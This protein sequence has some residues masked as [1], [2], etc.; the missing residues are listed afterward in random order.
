[1]NILD[2]FPLKDKKPRKNQIIALEWLADQDAKYLLLE[3]PVGVGKSAIGVCFAEYLK[4]LHADSPS[5]ASFILT[6]QRILQEQ[7]ANS[8]DR[9]IMSSLYGKS[10]YPCQ[11]RNTT[12]DI[13]SLFKE[14]KCEYCP[15]KSAIKWAR[16]SHNVVLNYKLALLMFGF[17]S[18]F[19]R[20]LL[21]ILDECHTMEEHLTEFDSVNI[22]HKRA[23][24]YGVREWPDSSK[25][26]IFKAQE[27]LREIY[28]PAADS[29]LMRLH[30]QVEPLLTAEALTKNDMK[31]VREYHR[32]QD[33][34]DEMMLFVRLPHEDLATNYVL[35]FD[36]TM[37]KFK[38]L[39]G[40][41]NFHTLLEPKGHRFL[42]MS[43]TIL[44]KEGFCRDL[45]LPPE[46]TAF[47]SLDSEF[48]SENRPVVYIPQMR[49]NATWKDDNRRNE[50]AKMLD[51]VKKILELHKDQSGIIHTGNFKI[52][53][54]LVNELSLWPESTH[55]LLHHNPN[56]GEDRNT[57]INRF[58][59]GQRPAL[60]ISPSITEGL[61]LFDDL[62]RF[63]IF[64]KVPFGYLG[65]QWIKRRM[66][67]SSEW[68]QR[69]ALIDII[70]GGG[71]V[72]RSQTD[73]GTVYILDE[74]WGYLYSKTFGMIPKWWKQGYQVI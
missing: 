62:A 64:A 61:D 1:M 9:A 13:G 28:L 8:F 55:D 66:Q 72:V 19:T 42:C 47:L 65:D 31:L 17:T 40:A 21:M 38:Q 25:T 70:Q 32:L 12:C 29:Y 16:T 35:I 30:H 58:I 39:T 14:H 4:A 23:T 5:N 6:P 37:F 33:Y 43:S 56:C 52:A 53:E 68:Y 51:G 27:W 71:R 15:H 59:D 44:N 60:L 48:A 2:F 10:N 18:V 26:D 7:Y 22:T 46:Q 41:R 45:G 20:R 67:M 24:K 3:A 69:R 50:R 49:M 34:V 74:S 54:W 63:A 11:T 73:Y 36:K 57:V